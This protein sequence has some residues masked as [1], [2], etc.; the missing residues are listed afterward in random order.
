MREISEE[1]EIRAEPMEVWSVLTDLRRYP[2]WNPFI[3]EAQ[4]S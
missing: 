3:R 4:C 2:E 1:T